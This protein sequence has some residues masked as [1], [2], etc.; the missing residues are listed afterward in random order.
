MDVIK[1]GLNWVLAS[2]QKTPRFSRVWPG[3]FWRLV[4]QTSTAARAVR[5]AL[6]LFGRITNKARAQAKRK[7]R[8]STIRARKKRTTT[9]SRVCSPRAR[10]WSKSS[11]TRCCS[12]QAKRTSE[13]NLTCCCKR[14]P[15]EERFFSFQ[16]AFS[17]I[18]AASTQNLPSGL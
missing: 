1:L 6:L 10:M 11:Q 16:M 17:Q 2:M 15:L 8:T 4:W 7:S 12:A 18:V 9:E 5:A 13:A 3:C 14:T